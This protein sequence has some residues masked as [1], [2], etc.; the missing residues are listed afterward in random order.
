MMLVNVK[1]EE[2]N[3]YFIAFNAWRRC[4]KRVDAQEKHY[5]GIH[6]RFLR[7]QVYRESQPKIGWTEQKYIEMDK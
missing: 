5:R 2:Q 4:R 3:E 1:T 6:D 7:D